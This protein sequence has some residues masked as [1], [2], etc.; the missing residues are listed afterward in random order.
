MQLAA[1]FES[2]TLTTYDL[3]QVDEGL[4][5]ELDDGV[6]I[7]GVPVYAGRVPEL[8]LK[9]IRNLTARAI[10]AVVVVLYGNR[11]YEDALVELR[12]VVTAKGFR[13]VAA[14]AFIGEHSY[15]TPLWPIALNRPDTADLQ[16]ATLFGKSIAQKLR[17]EYNPGALAIPGTI[18]YKERLPLGGIAPQTEPTQCTL[19]KACASV[20]PLG[21]IAVHQEVSTQAQHCIMCCA[22]VRACPQHARELHHPMVKSRRAMLVQNFSTRQEPELHL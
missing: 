8:F 15:A 16:Q 18:P 5:D 7:F 9:R 19:C 2:H 21:I 10:P 12:D 11:A 17:G 20:C 14:A 4:T 3:T 13:V 6:A 1:A 22:C